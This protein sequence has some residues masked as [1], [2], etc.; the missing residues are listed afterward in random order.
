MRRAY[1][2][3]YMAILCVCA[4]VAAGCSFHPQAPVNTAVIPVASAESRAAAAGW[5]QGGTWLDQHAD[6]NRIG[7]EKNIDLVFL[8]NSI[9]QSW[10]SRQRK[11]LAV[12]QQ[13]WDKYY[14]RRRAANFGISG[15]RTQHVLWRIDHGNFDHIRPR[16]I[17]LLIGTNNLPF[18]SA[19]EIAAGI[20][21]I[22]GRLRRKLPQTHLLVLGILPRGPEARSTWRARIKRVNQLI[23]DLGAQKGVDYLDLSDVF[24]HADGSARSE[25][26]AAD[27]LHLSPAGYAAWADAIEPVVKKYVP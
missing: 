13:V 5:S 26:M 17:V 1:I 8:G 11:V 15:D 25:L 6:I 21:K 22:A 16:L 7:S 19:E 18:N 3:L 27:F 9:T 23:K 2:F 20:K 4:L 12:G 24:L 14:G 10:G